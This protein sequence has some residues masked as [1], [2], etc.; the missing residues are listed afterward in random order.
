M[1]KPIPVD[2]I[3]IDHT[4]IFLGDKPVPGVIRWTARHEP[5]RGVFEV[6]LTLVTSS[7]HVSLDAPAGQIL[8]GPVGQQP[9]AKAPPADRPAQH[10]GVWPYYEYGTLRGTEPVLRAQWGRILN[11]TAEPLPVVCGRR[12]G[13]HVLVPAEQ[14]AR[15]AGDLCDLY[16][17]RA[18]LG[19]ALEILKNAC[20][21]HTEARPLL[22]RLGVLPPAAPRDR[23]P[24]SRAG[25][26]APVVDVAVTAPADETAPAGVTV[27]ISVPQSNGKTHTLTYRDAHLE[28]NATP[29]K[30]RGALDR[31]RLDIQGRLVRDL[32]E[33][34]EPAGGQS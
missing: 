2:P 13:D 32:M 10:W 17:A 24:Q 19:E 7:C 26:G 18:D 6:Q 16:L 29:A 20:P 34:A 30:A 33:T 15:L 31:I 27:R 8:G 23:T 9:I 4:N 11:P 12:D 3:R 5:D 1:I 28:L 14:L 22:E 25:S 21:E